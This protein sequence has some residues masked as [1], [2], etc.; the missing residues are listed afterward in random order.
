MTWCKRGNKRRRASWQGAGAIWASLSFRLTVYRAM[1][2]TTEKRFN[3]LQAAGGPLDPLLLLCTAVVGRRRV[4]ITRDLE[5]QGRFSTAVTA[6]QGVKVVIWIRTRAPL[7]LVE[8][9]VARF[10]TTGSRNEEEMAV[11]G[12]A[13]GVVDCG[14]GPPRYP[15]QGVTICRC[16]IPGYIAPTSISSPVYYDH[17]TQGSSSVRSTT[18]ASASTVGSRLPSC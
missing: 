3:P 17:P 5:S 7:L 11:A 16:Q 12:M 10:T 1:R 6:D 9:T 14:A 4:G 2:L 18:T 8:R 15:G 13:P